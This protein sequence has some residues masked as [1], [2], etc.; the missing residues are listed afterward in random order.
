MLLKIVATKIFYEASLTEPYLT[1][2]IISKLSLFCS[3]TACALSLK[4]N[5]NEGPILARG[6]ILPDEV[7]KSYQIFQKISIRQQC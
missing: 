4:G 6:Y 2:Q 3:S 5:R 1:K 7:L